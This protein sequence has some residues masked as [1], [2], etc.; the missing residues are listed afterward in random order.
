MPLD[1]QLLPIKNSFRKF[2]LKTKKIAMNIKKVKVDTK[3]LIHKK[4]CI[5]DYTD[6]YKVELK[7]N[8][9]T[10]LNSCAQV[11]IQN[12]KF[13]A[14]LIKLRN[15]LVRPFGLKSGE[16]NNKDIKFEKGAKLSFFDILEYNDNEILMC[17]TDKHLD[18]W[19]SIY[20]ENIKDMQ[21]VSITT[22]V[23]FNNRLGKIYFS[24]IKP[25]HK[26]IV[27]NCLKRMYK[28]L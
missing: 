20:L 10:N 5:A 14:F 3:S 22:M 21:H 13:E 6:C 24:I 26:L 4:H 27:K 9:Q 16:I 7:N 8:T 19:V 17:G 1:K 12:T 11:F 2:V 25:F 28:Y 23:K 18:V 15:I